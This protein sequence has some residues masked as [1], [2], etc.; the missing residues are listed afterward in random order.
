MRTL[1]R[2]AIGFVVFAGGLT[3]LVYGIAQAITTG[4]C[5]SSSNGM[6]YGPACPSGMGPMIMLMILGT[7]AAL[8]GAGIASVR[9]S[10]GGVA[11]LGG[12]GRFIAALIVAV[13]ASVVLGFVD[14]H[15]DDTRPG[16]EI[17]AAVVAP[18]LLFT[19]PAI[20]V[21]EARKV[22]PAAAPEHDGPITWEKR[23][24][25]TTT[26]AKPV[27]SANAEDIASRLR[28]LDQLRASG[29]LGDDEYKQ[30]RTQILAEL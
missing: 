23:A 15:S 7:F 2:I 12:V 30:R 16:L 22:K 18:L 3:F 10:R 6:S 11:V 29:L 20:G 8:I 1:P 13:V 4:S 27:T 17:F 5:G 25:E 19:I 28:Q 24:A 9:S 21:V 26:T 14:L